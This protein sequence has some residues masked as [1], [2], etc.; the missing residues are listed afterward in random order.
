MGQGFP[1][2]R[3]GI[4]MSAGT[5]IAQSGTVVFSNSNNVTFGAQISASSFVI[6]ATAAVLGSISA[7]T[8]QITSGQVVLSN[9]NGISF[10]ANGQTITA[11]LPSI[12]YWDNRFQEGAQS[13]VLSSS[14]PNL[15]LQI[16]SFA[17]PIAATRADMFARLTVVGS[18]AGSYTI[19]MGIYTMSGSTASRAS[20]S[21]VAVTWN[22]GTSNAVSLYGGQSDIRYRSVPLGTWNI[23]P[24]NYMI[25]VIYSISGVAG[26]TGSMS[27]YG[28]IGANLNTIAVPGGGAQS[29]YFADGL[30]TTG[31]AALPA[32]IHLS[33]IA[34]TFTASSVEMQPYLQLAGT[35]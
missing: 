35:F 23:S 18:T 26:T 19:S 10:G 34:Q 27:V 7:G 21:S 8:T 22:S 30:Y 14:A 4:A 2:Q 5:G 25:G 28:A 24:G 1:N 3:N 31:T 13:A 16:A 20:S 9:S 32:S 6:T 12:S 29:A 15:S 11:Q 33:D 17:L